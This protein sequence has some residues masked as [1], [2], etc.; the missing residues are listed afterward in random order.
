M[1]ELSRQ[2]IH[3]SGIAFIILAQFVEKQITV[4]YF[5]LIALTFLL[6]SFYI[7]NEQNRFKKL[8]HIVDSKIRSTVLRFERPGI[9][10]QG[11]FWFYFSCGLTFLLFPFPIATAA[12]II[13]A[14]SDSLSTLVGFH[15]GKKKIV[16]KKTLEGTAVFFL[17]AAAIAYVFFPQRAI[18][19]A[20]AATVGELLPEASPALKRKGLLD[21]N[22]LIPLFAAA[23]LVSY[24]LF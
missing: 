16:G 24:N 13:L 12:C 14:I 4:L 17:S 3:L 11:A 6:Y 22:L 1:N 5:F 9:P 20:L 23:A 19:A 15:V 2:L 8:F 7:R 10:L 21:D 18:I